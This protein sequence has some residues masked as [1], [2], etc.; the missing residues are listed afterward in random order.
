[1]CIIDD[2]IFIFDQNIKILFK[3]IAKPEEN[4]ILK[5]EINKYYKIVEKE[6]YKLIKMYKYILYFDINNF[7]DFFFQ[8]II[9]LDQDIIDNIILSQE[10]INNYYI[11]YIKNSYLKINNIANYIYSFIHYVNNIL[12]KKLYYNDY[13]TI[14]NQIEEFA[15][16]CLSIKSI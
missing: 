6:L 14:I 1:M 12:K 15:N 11:N 16:I 5:E 7:S 8:F 4:V 13:F 3:S 2:Q 10:D 9:K